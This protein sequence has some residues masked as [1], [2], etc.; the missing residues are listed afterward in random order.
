MRTG[1]IVFL[2]FVTTTAG[3]QQWKLRSFCGGARQ[4]EL[5]PV[6]NNPMMLEPFMK[7]ANSYRAFINTLE[8]NGLLGG[9]EI[10]LFKNYYLN[11]TWHRPGAASRFWKKTNVQAGGWISNQLVKE[12]MALTNHDA[13]FSPTDTVLH[14]HHYTIAQHLQFAGLNAGLNWRG[15]LSNKLSYTAGFQMQGGI[16]FR[17]HY[18]H[19]LDS[20]WVH[21]PANIRRSSTTALQARKGK[22]FFQWQAMIP[23]GVE[24]DLYRQRIFVRAEFLA[25]MVGGQF[26]S[27]EFAMNEAHGFGLW[28]VYGINR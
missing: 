5:N 10:Q 11:A 25:G 8:Y 19:Q 24:V 1:F 28:L 15:R 6:G 12:G 21:Y 2:F 20:N 14:R 18:N 22:N 26:R 13:T 7:D 27:S 16:A 17:H 23:L 9:G 4:F 3:A